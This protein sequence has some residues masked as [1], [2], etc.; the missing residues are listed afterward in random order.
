MGTQKQSPSNPQ[1]L[2]KGGGELVEVTLKQILEDRELVKQL[3]NK[4]GDKK[5]GSNRFTYYRLCADEGCVN[6]IFHLRGG[7]QILDIA[8]IG[9]QFI[10]CC[11]F[12]YSNITAFDG[13]RVYDENEAQRLV[14]VVYDDEEL[15]A[16]CPWIWGYLER[17]EGG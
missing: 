2:E 16:V 14:I 15:T 10:V 7:K 9:D 6:G 13:C 11:C 5:L 1:P 12:V 3:I 17:D 8:K 4:F